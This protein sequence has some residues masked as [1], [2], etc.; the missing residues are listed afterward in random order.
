MP[1]GGADDLVRSMERLTGALEKLGKG[2]AKSERA[3]EKN[4]RSLGSRLG[5][6]AGAAVTGVA[7]AAVGAGL[8]G[9]RG[10]VEWNRLQLEI[11]MV[12]REL[13]G[14]FLPA[15]KFATGA[16]Q[17]LR[18]GLERLTPRGQNQLLLGGLAFG[19]LAAAGLARAGLGGLFGGLF[20][21]GAAVAG[22]A[23]AAGA[24]RG[25]GLRAGLGLG[26]G[27]ALASSYGYG[28]EVA[29]GGAA[30]GGLASLAR[31]KG[32]LRGAGRIGGPLALGSIAAEAVSGDYYT[33]LRARGHS[34]L[35]SIVGAAGG[36]VMDFLSGG[37]YGE[38]FRKRMGSGTGPF[39]SAE[40]LSA[41]RGGAAAPDAKRRMVTIAD[42]GF[43]ASGSAFERLTTRL[44]LSDAGEEP[45]KEASDLL[46]DIR[47][48]LVDAVTRTDRP[49]IK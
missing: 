43:E 42:A 41:F 7:G 47:D 5:G 27:G 49:S 11:Q 39:S 10:T 4:T 34:K 6:A 32:F 1:G 26:L 37:A 36:G 20:G 2:T 14:A 12:S 9:F 15:I 25:L 16:L 30:V 21:G 48:I 38:A 17:M 46:A 29:A 35:T 33:E 28:T 45:K 13:A 31:G 44:A 22:A 18:K 3:L 24:A 40:A 8:A 23:G 19:G